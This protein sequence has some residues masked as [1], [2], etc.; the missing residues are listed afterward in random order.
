MTQADTP[1]S[2]QPL[3]TPIP[4]NDV[5]AAREYVLAAIADLKAANIAVPISL[6]RAAHAPS[7]SLRT[8]YAAI[9]AHREAYAAYDAMP[10][11]GPDE[12]NDAAFSALDSASQRLLQAE[13]ST[14]AGLIALLRYM[15]PLLSGTGGASAAA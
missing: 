5:A 15:A 4:D 3:S 9:E 1:D 6:H 11:D 8:V 14:T 7:Y 10:A 13:A 2:T 12:E